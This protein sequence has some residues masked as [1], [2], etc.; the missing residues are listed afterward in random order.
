MVKLRQIVNI[1]IMALFQRLEGGYPTFWKSVELATGRVRWNLMRLKTKFITTSCTW[2]WS[3][4]EKL[5]W[6][7]CSV[8]ALRESGLLFGGVQLGVFISDLA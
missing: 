5:T 2:E 3:S 7:L 4:K 6:K 8:W 1:S